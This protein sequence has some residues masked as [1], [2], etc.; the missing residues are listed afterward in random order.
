MYDTI[1]SYYKLFCDEEGDNNQ[2]TPYHPMSKHKDL[3]Y[4]SRW[5]KINEI[6]HPDFW[7]LLASIGWLGGVS[8]Y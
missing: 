1:L 3:D 7:L 2:P 4:V 6:I 5:K 8:C